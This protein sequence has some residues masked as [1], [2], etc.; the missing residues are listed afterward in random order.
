MQEHPLI[1][2]DISA[3]THVD[4]TVSQQQQQSIFLLFAEVP[5]ACVK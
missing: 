4:S 1:P 5:E 3:Y 2:L